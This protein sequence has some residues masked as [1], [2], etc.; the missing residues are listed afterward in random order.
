MEKS[1]LEFFLKGDIVLD[2]DSFIINLVI[3]SILSFIVQL[4]YLKFSTTLSNRLDFSKNFVVS[5]TTNH[6]FIHKNA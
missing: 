1:D 3:A 2:L 5:V 4:F 6:T